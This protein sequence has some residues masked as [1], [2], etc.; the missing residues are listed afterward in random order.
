MVNVD[1]VYQ[2]VQALANKE[3]R[4][5]LTPQE[6]NL[7]ANQAQNDIFEQ[8]LYDLAAMRE[9]RP[10]QRELGDSVRHVLYKIART[11]GATVNI[12]AVPGGIS[13]A[14]NEHNG[15]IFVT[16]G[17]ER[18]TVRKIENIDEIYNLRDSKW[19][20]EAF[21]EVVYFEDG[22]GRIQ[23]WGNPT[24]S[25]IE[26]ITTGVQ[27]ERID[28]R[29][30]LVNWGYVII[31]ETPLYDP[32]S[33]QNFDLDI[34]ERTELVAKILKLAGVSM[35]DQEVYQA[36]QTEEALITQKENK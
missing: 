28:G 21:D 32:A 3:Q 15:R 19:H 12:V 29:P 31:N 34:S 20:Q 35:E 17:G 23:V 13:V 24:G 18:K 2:T 25:L 4:G 30:G 27:Q 5:Y 16:I 9:A 22:V 1:T 7:F 11:T 14:I 10:E 26:Q 33:S 36:G 8:Y 6:F